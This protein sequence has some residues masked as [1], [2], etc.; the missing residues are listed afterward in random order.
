MPRAWRFAATIVIAVAATHLLWRDPHAAA[1]LAFRLIPVL[2]FVAA[3]SVVVNLAEEAGVFTALT[4]RVAGGRWKIWMVA[5]CLATVSTVF[6]SLD[7]TVLLVT[8]LVIAL[9]R[10]TGVNAVALSL[11]VIWVANLGSLLL[12]VSNL[13]N[14]LAVS[15]PV[16]DGQGDF[17]AHSWAPAVAALVVALV[18][19]AFVLAH[20]PDDAVKIPSTDHSPRSP[21]LFPS[22]LVLA[23]LLPLL[24][25]PVPFWLSS[26]LAAAVLAFLTT[27]Q[28]NHRSALSPGLIPWSSLT[29]ITTLSTLAASVHAAGAADWVRG[30]FPHAANGSGGSASFANS[31]PCRRSAVSCPTS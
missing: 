26:C 10:R 21:L 12:P 29:M 28:L 7:T 1:A 14:L 4:Q 24:A 31:C 20:A 23:V 8:P 19:A 27:R 15:G 3:M 11:G 30:L 2:V 5:M 22:L 9:A 25:S 13:T 6:L 17:V 16:F 18:S